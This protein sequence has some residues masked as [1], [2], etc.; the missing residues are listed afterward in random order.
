[1]PEIKKRK[2]SVVIPVYNEQATIAKTLKRVSAALLPADWDKEIIIVDD[3]STDG[4]GETLKSWSSRATIISSPT[5]HGKGAALKLGFKA[6]TGDYLIIQDA[7]LEYDPA[8]YSK[9][10]QPIIEGRSEIA[11]G[12]RIL[13]KNAVPFSRVY[14]YGGLLIT[15]VFNALFGTRITDVATC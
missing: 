12:S 4:T 3:G 10:L 13:N 6:A 7:D 8:D 11:F 15:K 1:M 14:F 5:N 9:L 2:L